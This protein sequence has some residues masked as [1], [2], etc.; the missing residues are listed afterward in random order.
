MKT[1]ILLLLAVASIS[2]RLEALTWEW[3]FDSNTPNAALGDGTLEWSTITAQTTTKYK[4][5]NGT[6]VPHV[7][8]SPAGYLHIPAYPNP[9]DYA[10]LYFNDSTPNGGGIYLNQY[11]VIMDVYYAG[12]NAWLPFFNTNTNNENDADFYVNP[13]G[14]LGIGPLGYSPPGTITPDMW[15]R[16]V[17]AVDLVSGVVSYYIDGSIAFE[18]VPA[19]ASLVDGRFSLYTGVDPNPEL[20]IG[21]EGDSGAVYTREWFLASFA[22]TDHTLTADEVAALGE[23][24]APGIYVTGT[25]PP[26]TPQI[27]IAAGAG[28]VTLN[29]EPVG[30]LLQRSLDLSTWTTVPGSNTV[31]THTEPVSAAENAVW[32]RLARP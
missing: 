14:A 9:A 10:K 5:T 12:E 3:T 27:Q 16:V 19:G 31:K 4:T 15:H 6:T 25:T 18:R 20:I 26:E 17:F 30:V 11:S 28:S 7:N 23:P 2:T 8:G 32:F 21:N 22:V 24:K 1:P 29:W 13:E